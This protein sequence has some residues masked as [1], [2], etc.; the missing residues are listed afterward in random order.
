VKLVPLLPEYVREGEPLPFGLRD[1]SGRLLLAAGQ[2][3]RNVQRLRELTGQALFADEYE[4][5]DWH[6]R[7]TGAMDARIRQGATLIEVAAARPEALPRD[8]QSG[9]AL[10][11]GQA[12]GELV[13][14]LDAVLR[15]VRPQGEWRTRLMSVHLRAR[16]LAERRPDASLYHLVYEAACSTR[17]YSC[18]HALL[19]MLICEQAAPLLGWARP[20]IDSLGRAALAM[21]VSMLRLQDQMAESEW[22]L[23]ADQRAE[24]DAHAEK[25]AAML[26]AAGLA[27]PLCLQTVRL[28]HGAGLGGPPLAAL[29]PDHQLAHLL[30]RVDKFSAK[31]SV[32]ASREPMSPV[33][34]ARQACLGPS[35]LPDEIGGA[36]LR[37]VGL[38]PPGSFVELAC[39]EI[40]IVVARGRR[41]NVPYVAALVSASGNVIAEP[42]LRDTLDRRYA[43]KAAVPHGAVKVRPPHDRLMALRRPSATA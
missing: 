33:L 11:L 19:T 6:R 13:D 36:L 7:L 3:V 40:G 25:S 23:S 39:G 15:D 18:Q 28:H 38:Y 9:P 21:N 31:I 37:A 4:S 34:A 30:H 2:Q 29:P 1:A 12:W 8:G 20:W 10:P 22:A 24:I 14:Q 16:Q 32:R 26:E 42:A 43:V 27:D 5:A 41:A 17:K 35:G